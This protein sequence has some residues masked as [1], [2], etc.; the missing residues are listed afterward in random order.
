MLQSLPWLSGCASPTWR[1]REG[2]ANLN[3]GPA[4]RYHGGGSG[5]MHGRLTSGPN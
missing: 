2:P 5:S 4:A 1:K 3:S